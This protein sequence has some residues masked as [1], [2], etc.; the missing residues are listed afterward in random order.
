[1]L[2]VVL[3]AVSSFQPAL[4]LRASSRQPNGYI[5]AFDAPHQ[6]QSP[7]GRVACDFA[8]HCGSS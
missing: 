2:L 4:L 1:L 6:P 5:T 7:G 3:L 8:L